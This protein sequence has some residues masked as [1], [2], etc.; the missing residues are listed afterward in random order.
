MKN[1]RQICSVL[2][3]ALLAVSFV[4]ASAQ[5]LPTPTFGGA[6]VQKTTSPT[7]T[8]NS[9]TTG[10][11]VNSVLGQKVGATQW[12][13]GL[14]G[15]TDQFQVDR[16]VGGVL[17]DSPLTISNANGDVTVNGDNFLI[18]DVGRVSQTDNAPAMSIIST[19]GVGFATYVTNYGLYV[20]RHQTSTGKGDRIGAGFIQRCDA[21]LAEH[22]CVGS[23]SFV[24]AGGAGAGNYTGSNPRV[25]IPSGMASV[26]NAIG[27]EINTETHSAI[28]LK[29]GLLIGD[30]NQSGPDN[31]TT[32]GTLLDSA[33]MIASQPIGGA[34]VGFNC[35]TCGYNKGITFGESAAGYPQTFPIRT[36][37]TLIEAANPT[38]KLNFGFDL[39][40]MAAGFDYGALALPVNSPKN[41]IV[42]GYD[43]RGGI[44]SSTA[45]TVGPQMIFTDNGLFMINAIGGSMAGFWNDGR[46]QMPLTTPAS[47]SAACTAGQTT[48]DA[49]YH[50]VCVA[51][52]TWKR[53][54]LAA[55]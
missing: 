2:A 33:V 4:T 22:S 31:S 37:G 36:G 16:Y 49:N 23:S 39:T 17:V 7:L 38:R 6:T 50:Y 43:R 14:G 26:G 28:G 40:G 11:G 42:W 41:A 54:A 19:E 10:S 18:N 35:T 47:S 15:S 34:L 46:I 8:L 13:L 44:I 29:Y 3:A 53:A 12:R 9:S 1:H 52:N 48:H 5:S 21:T 55:F 25:L 20:D 27:E 24:V 32:A 45:T 30:L 51:T